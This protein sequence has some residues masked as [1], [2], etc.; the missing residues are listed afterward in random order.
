LVCIDPAMVRLFWPHARNLIVRAIARGGIGRFADVERD[1]LAGAALLWLAWD[2]RAIA[3]AAVTELVAI[4]IGKVCVI[5]ACGG[6]QMRRWLPLI[7]TI[8]DYARAEGCTRIRFFGRMGWVRVLPHY[9]MSRVIL[10]RR[11]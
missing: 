5:V 10:E 8:E 3:A 11:P 4:D 1:V 9:R 6:R 2:G 7:A